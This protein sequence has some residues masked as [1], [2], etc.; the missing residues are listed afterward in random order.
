TVYPAGPDRD[1]WRP[2]SDPRGTG[3]A[4]S[5]G[6]TWPSRAEPG[7]VT[8][9]SVLVGRDDLTAGLGADGPPHGQADRLLDEL[10]MAVAETDVDAAGVAAAGRP[11]AAQ[12][13]TAGAV[14]TRIRVRG[15]HVV[16]GG[17]VGHDGEP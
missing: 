12:E 2:R 16:V 10:D 7:Q 9:R 5:A 14:D 6:L 8:S 4:G 11:G 17:P 3:T 15:H 13:V 1:G